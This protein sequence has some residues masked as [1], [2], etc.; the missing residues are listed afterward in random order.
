MESEPVAEPETK[1]HRDNRGYRGSEGSGYQYSGLE[2]ARAFNFC[3][4]IFN[5]HIAPVKLV[6]LALISQSYIK[7]GTTGTNVVNVNFP[8]LT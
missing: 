1:A 2:L 6:T 4:P 8:G 3:K 7:D 5:L